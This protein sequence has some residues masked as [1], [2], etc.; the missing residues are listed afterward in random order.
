[1]AA[2]AF[3]A[4]ALPALAIFDSGCDTG[5]HR[6]DGRCQYVV[7]WTIVAGERGAECEYGDRR[8]NGG[9][10][11]NATDLAWSLCAPICGGDGDLSATPVDDLAGRS[12]SIGTGDRVW[13]GRGCVRDWNARSCY[14]AM[15]RD[16]VWRTECECDFAKCDTCGN[17]DDGRCAGDFWEF[18]WGDTAICGRTEV[19]MKNI[20]GTARIPFDYLRLTSTP[21]QCRKTFTITPKLPISFGR[22]MAF[23]NPE[24]FS[25]QFGG[26]L[27]G[28]RPID[29]LFGFLTI[30]GVCLLFASTLDMNPPPL[31]STLQFDLGDL[32]PNS[33]KIFSIEIKNPTKT[34]IQLLSPETT[35]SCTKIKL[36]RET[37][38]KSELVELSGAI[39]TPSESTE[40]DVTVAVPFKYAGR[41]ESKGVI[42][43]HLK[44]RT[45]LEIEPGS[46]P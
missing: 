14:L 25:K 44:A 36:S 24:C 13:V 10:F 39:R 3:Y 42:L 12:R 17:V 29:L 27:K 41:E 19:A 5:D 28:T 20:R 11:G 38:R 22:S 45:K 2:F 18:F 32:K 33:S 6:N 21:R 34:T 1:M 9:D 37:L 40:I 35:C 30:F 4:I 15:A 43:V 31:G 16:W 7:V 46:Q 23:V 8:C 26:L